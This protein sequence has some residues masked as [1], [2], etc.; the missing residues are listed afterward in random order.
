MPTVNPEIIQNLKSFDSPT[1]FNA[2]VKKLGLP[3]EEYTSR[4]I[5][6]LLPELGTV[7]GYAVTAEV[8]TNDSDSPAIEWLD[9][10]EYMEQ[11]SGPIVAVVKDVDSRPGR[12]AS[13]GDGMARLFKRLGA[14]GAI[15]DGSV[16]DLAGIRTA[17]LPIWGWGTVSGHGVFNLTR[18][19]ASVTVGQ[20]R[21]HPDDLI[22]ADGDGCV[23]IPTEHAEDILRLA[24]E[25]SDS[26]ARAFEFFDSPDFTVAELREQRK[27][28][29]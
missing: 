2:M 4:D 16:R 15:V 23:R 3:N 6:Y 11:H 9:F 13:F 29:L 12:G 10:Y 19:N 22:F 5:R 28:K 24:G 21:I 8:T 17:G 14:V 20:V 27:K 25:I 18:F 7:V 1:V 26:E